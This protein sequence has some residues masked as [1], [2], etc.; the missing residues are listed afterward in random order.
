ML[1]WSDP[2]ESVTSLKVGVVPSSIGLDPQE[3][4]DDPDRNGVFRIT[5]P[6]T[7]VIKVIQS[8]GENERIDEYTLDGLTLMSEDQGEG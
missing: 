4:I 1:H 3:C 8:D 5:N 6:A 2:D 7:Q